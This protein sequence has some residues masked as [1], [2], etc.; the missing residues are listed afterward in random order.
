MQR[1][2]YGVRLGLK[3][4]RIS[5]RANMSHPHIQDEKETV[6]H[7]EGDEHPKVDKEAAVVDDYVPGSPE[8]KALV[9]KIDRHLLPV[10]WVMYIFNYIDRTNI[11]VSCVP[12]IWPCTSVDEVERQSRRNAGRLQVDFER[13][14]VDPLH[15]FRRKFKLFL[16]MQRSASHNS[17]ISYSRSPQTCFSLDPSRLSSCMWLLRFIASHHCQLIL[18]TRS[19]VRMGRCQSCGSR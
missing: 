1:G 11:G 19:H 9:R 6:Q 16:G 15:L 4:P 12:S 17:R 3:T 10:L 14:F 2:I 7:Y 5:T 8:E 18:Q 13:L